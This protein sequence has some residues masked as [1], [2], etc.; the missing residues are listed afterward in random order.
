MPGCILYFVFGAVAAY[1]GM[2]L[3]RLF[4]AFDSHER[5]CR[6]YGDIAERVFEAYGP[7]AAMM[8]KWWTA[9]FQFAQL[10]MNVSIIILGSGQALYQIANNSVCFI[11]LSA[12]FTGAGILCGLIKQL[13]SLSHL[14]NSCIWINIFVCIATLAVASY[15]PPLTNINDSAPSSVFQAGYIP[16]DANG[17]GLVAATGV[18]FGS[19]PF[20]LQL[21]AITTMIYA[22]GGATIFVEFMAEMKQPRDFWKAWAI[23]LFIIMSCYFSYGVALYAMQGMYTAVQCI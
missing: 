2:I 7:R 5:P 14:A 16:T 17:N 21:N 22:Y 15:T 10:W 18:A 13:R 6:T 11:G 8:A 3:L 12:A 23:S 9:F 1:A 4:L 19:F 20:S